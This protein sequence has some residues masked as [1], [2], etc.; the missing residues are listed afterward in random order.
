[1]RN[2]NCLVTMSIG[3]VYKEL[4][5]PLTH[6]SLRDYAY[7]MG[8]DFEVI[9]DRKLNDTYQEFWEKLRMREYLDDYERVL[10]MDSDIIVHPKCPSIFELVPTDCLGMTNEN[11][12]QCTTGKDSE[13]NYF[14]KRVGIPMP[15]WDGRYF[16]IGVVCFGQAH[17]EIFSDPPTMITAAFPEQDWVNVQIA[18]LAPKMFCI[19]CKYHDWKFLMKA[20]AEIDKLAKFNRFVIHYAGQKKNAILAEEIKGDLLAWNA[21]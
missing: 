9:D 1:M 19:P 10:F 16:N 12:L 7:R 13:L 14:C 2:N 3:K 11:H 18:R 20:D 8:S 6:P 5:S 17:R 15:D 21:I 4:I